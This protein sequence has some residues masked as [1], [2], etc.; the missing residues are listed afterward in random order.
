MYSIN[1]LQLIR[2]LP[3]QDLD[4]VLDLVAARTKADHAIL[5]M[6]DED[7]QNAIYLPRPRFS[8]QNDASFSRRFG[9]HYCD[10]IRT[11]GKTVC[12]NDVRLE[13]HIEPSALMVEN[14]IFAFLGA[15]ILDPNSE[16]IGT[17]VALSKHPRLWNKT[18]KKDIE[19]FAGLV[20]KMV[21]LRASLE[22]IKCLAVET[23]QER[24][25]S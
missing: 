8:W 18:E 2:D 21:L 9:P 19:R 22:T 24:K 12:I 23:Q 13:K 25:G 11:T 5:T 1:E 10:L 14:E 6:L 3:D 4:W 16:V 15:P 20:N 7:G 17:L